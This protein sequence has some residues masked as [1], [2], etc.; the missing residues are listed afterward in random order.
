M[1][2]KCKTESE[3]FNEWD[4]TRVIY[5]ETWECELKETDDVSGMR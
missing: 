5:R 3:L 1:S 4:R 2:Q